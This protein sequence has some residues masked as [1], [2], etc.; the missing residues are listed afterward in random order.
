MEFPVYMYI[1][2]DINDPNGLTDNY[3]G[4]TKLKDLEVL[5]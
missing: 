5:E 2:N 4:L 1:N 3:L